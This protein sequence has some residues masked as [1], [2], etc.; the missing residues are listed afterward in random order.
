M[1]RGGIALLLKRIVCLHP[2]LTHCRECGLRHECVYPAVFEP[3]PPLD[4]DVLRT[5][6]DVPL[7]IVLRLPTQWQ[8]AYQAGDRLIFGMVLMGE[9]IRHLPYLV[10]AVE[11]LGQNGL[12]P[13]R[14]RFRLAA[15][16]AQLP[17]GTQL[18][19]YVAGLM[20][21]VQAAYSSQ[22]RQ[23]APTETDTLTLAFVTPTR[24]KHD[25]HFLHET[26]PFHVLIRTLLRRISSLSYFHGGQ[27][28]ETDYRGWIERAEGIAIPQTDVQMTVTPRCST[29]QQQRINLGGIVGSVT[30]CGDMA[31]FLPLLRLG[32]LIHVGKGAVFGNGQYRVGVE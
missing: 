23:G 9:P 5:H 6:Q 18:P 17:D 8:P 14:V 7:G 22:Q 27:R 13:E 30:Y 32:E 19:V 3:A 20:Y 1:L 21:N 2:Q 24:I 10:A 12:G 11:R 28:W 25:D 26:P 15:V 16:H 4:S 29:D 31:P